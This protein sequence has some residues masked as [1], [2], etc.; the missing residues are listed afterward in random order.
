MSNESSKKERSTGKISRDPAQEAY[1][2]D[3]LEQLAN[4]GILDRKGWEYAEDGSR[5]RLY[6]LTEY[7]RVWVKWRR[8]SGAA[9]DLLGGPV[10]SVNC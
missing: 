10:E 6:S 5:K 8:T 2:N 4:E 7:G 9:Q 1:I 3:Y